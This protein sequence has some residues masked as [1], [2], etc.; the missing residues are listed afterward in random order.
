MWSGLS[1]GCGKRPQ[2]ERLCHCPV[3]RGHR[4]QYRVLPTITEWLPSHFRIRCT[5]NPRRPGDRLRVAC[6]GR[7]GPRSR[8]GSPGDRSGHGH[9]PPPDSITPS[10]SLYPPPFF[11]LIFGVGPVPLTDAHHD[12]PI[13]RFS[14]LPR[15]FR[16]G[17]KGR[18]TPQRRG[19]AYAQRGRVIVHRSPLLLRARGPGSTRARR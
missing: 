8:Q 3:G 15:R 14:A 1:R 6:P 5:F 2:R 12:T 7:P 18:G 16:P 4:V 17:G 19:S 11:P 10:G 9:P 13:P